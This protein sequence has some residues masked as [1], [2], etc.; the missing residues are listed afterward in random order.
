VRRWLLS[1]GAAAMYC[2]GLTSMQ[3]SETGGRTAAERG[4]E[5]VLRQPLNPGFWSLQA[6]EDAWKRWGVAEKPA[7]YGRAFRERY[8]LHAAPYDNRGLPL[9]LMQSNRLL[10]K[11][12]VN[13]CLLCHAGSIA[14][15]TYIGLGNASLDFQALFDELSE[16][17]GIKI[18]LPFQFSYVRGTIDPVSPVAFL[19]RFRDADLNLRK[20]IGLTYFKD[21][22]SDPPAWWLIKRKKTRD[23]TGGIDARSTRVDLVNLL[24]PLHS[25]EHIKK[26]EAVFADILAFL[27]NIESPKYPFA[28]D[29]ELAERGHTVFDRHCAKCH[30]TYGPDGAYPN[31]IVS[32]EKLGTDPVLAEAVSEKNMEHFN[33]SWLAQQ[34]GPDGER[35]RVTEHHGYQAPPLDGIWA[36][37]PYFHN[38]SV[39]TVYHVL[40]SKARP[41]IYT[42]SFRTAEVEYDPV[43]LGWKIQELAKS[44]DPTLPADERRKVYDTTQRGRRNSGHLYGDKLTEEER[45]AVIEYLKTL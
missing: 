21:V 24:S 7:D 35:F 14:G 1:V 5:I 26:Q 2:I 4:R 34:V 30:G 31:R 39:P 45:L 32:I 33:K 19:M 41:K 12:I 11:G 40:N 9:G 13:N 38:A 37:A 44:P 17:D 3:S 10:Q 43:K 25:G 22:C 36:T 29:A 18:E 15:R 42:R 16:A 27:H 20:P 23:W 6:Y 28:I 8:G